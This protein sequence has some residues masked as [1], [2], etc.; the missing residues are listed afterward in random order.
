MI[1]KD[2][3]VVTELTTNKNGLAVSQPL[4]VG[5]YKLKEVQAP[6]GYMLMK[7]P[8]EVNVTGGVS[9]QK[10]TIENSKNEWIIPETGGTGTIVFM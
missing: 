2:G 10:I 3:D 6:V 8:I 1:N 7:E 9:T 4:L 5:Q